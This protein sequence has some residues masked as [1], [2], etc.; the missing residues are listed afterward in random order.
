[1][2]ETFED[3]LKKLLEVYKAFKCKKKKKKKIPTYLPTC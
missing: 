3:I 2:D 1:M